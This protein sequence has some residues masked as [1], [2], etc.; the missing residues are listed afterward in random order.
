MCFSKLLS[1]QIVRIFK[2]EYANSML[3][4]KYY[5]SHVEIAEGSA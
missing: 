1:T 4:P 3:S 2:N 5:K